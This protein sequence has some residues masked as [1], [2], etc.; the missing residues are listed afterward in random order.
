[1]TASSF[2]DKLSMKLSPGVSRRGFFTRTALVGAGLAVAP[3]DLVLKPGT[4]YAAICNCYGSNCECGSMCCDG[5]TEFCCTIYGNN[6]CPAGTLL[7]GWW[8]ADGTGLCGGPRYYMDC[9]AACNGCGCGGN[10]ICS[11]ACSGT[12]CGCANGD[13]GNRKSGCTMF[14]YGQCNQ[15]TACVGPIVCRVVTCIPPWQ[16]DATCSTFTLVDQNT[17][18]HDR[19]CLHSTVGSLDALA[20]AGGAVRLTGWALDFDTNGPIPVDVYVDGRNAGRFTA[21]AIRNDIAKAYP[22][23]GPAHGFDVTVP[24]SPGLHN[25]DVFAI[26]VGP[27]AV[28]PSIGHRQFATANPYGSFDYVAGGLQNI[29]VAGWAYDPDTADPI[30]VH[31]YIDGV[32]VGAYSANFSRVDVGNHG[33][34]ITLP[35]ATGTHTVSIYAINAG[36]GN[37]NTLLGTRVVDVNPW[38]LGSV[39][40]VA[41]GAGTVRAVGW[42]LDPDT[43]APIDVHLYVDGVKA[44]AVTA[45][46]ARPDIAATF[47]G[48]GANHGFDITVPVG[49]GQ[50]TVDVYAINVGNGGAVNPLLGRRIV[51]VSTLPFGNVEQALAQIG[52]VRVAGWAMDPDTT[53]PIDVH[54]YVDGVKRGQATADLNRPDVAAAFPGR[55]AQHGFDVTVPVP[56]N[57]PHVIHVYGINVGTGSSNPLLGTKGVTTGGNPFGSLDDVAVSPGS[58][59]LAGWALDPDASTATDV[60]VYVD[61]VKTVVTTASLPRGDIAAAFPGAGADHGYDITIPIAPGQHRFDVYAINLGTGTANPL[62]GT[63]TVTVP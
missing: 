42:T 38:P 31:V 39:D 48:Y 28:N 15:G 56:T 27:G 51:N 12:G 34:D 24:L 6:Q 44:T 16:I 36:P 9:N 10:G 60:H 53:A 5:Y 11:G 25:I 50:H 4:A 23:M 21:N 61:G 8:K 29:R 47:P 35:C 41:G 1:M 62:I 63:R 22:G 40:L 43:S 57:G 33:F 14:R 55:G 30:A 17:A 19:P 49:D 7:G 46:V 45:N 32:N 37:A 52:Q 58:V 18:S 20:D 3:V 54:V 13:C 26:G 59:K 2:V